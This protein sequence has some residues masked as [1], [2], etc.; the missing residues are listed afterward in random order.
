VSICPVIL[1]RGKG[2]RV[3]TPFINAFQK[4]KAWNM[5]KSS[6]NLGNFKTCFF[7]PQNVAISKKKNS[8]LEMW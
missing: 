3:S 4:K 8:L 2:V 6:T 1:L 7:P 5:P